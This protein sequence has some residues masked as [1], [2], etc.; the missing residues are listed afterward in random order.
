[1]SNDDLRQ[2]L[3]QVHERLGNVSTLD[4]PAREQLITVMHDIERALGGDGA[5]AAPDADR[6]ESLAV[7][8][9]AKHPAISETLRQLVDALG[10]AGI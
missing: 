7:Q 10:K 5:G 2:L 6:L 3:A 4:A 1:M 8:F 9:Q